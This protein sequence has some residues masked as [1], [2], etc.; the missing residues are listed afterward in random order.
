MQANNNNPEFLYSEPGGS[1]AARDL[2]IGK[3]GA[4]TGSASGGGSLFTD[5]GQDF[6]AAPF[7]TKPGDILRITA[8]SNQGDYVITA[9]NSGTEL[10]VGGEFVAEAGISYDIFDP[11]MPN[12]GAALSAGTPSDPTSPPPYVPG[13]VYI[14]RTQYNGLASATITFARNGVYDS[15]WDP[16]LTAGDFAKTYIHNLGALP[17]SVELWVRVDSTSPAYRPLVRRQVLTNFDTGDGTVDPTD[18]KTAELLVPSMFYSVTET[19]ITVD[20]FNATTDPA[21]PAALFTDSAGVDQVAGDLRV[22][23]RR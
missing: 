22:I 9:V 2:R 23:V 20:L 11:A 13:R 17:A 19:S 12:I 10:Q 7:A 16:G 21:N 4:G 8:G 18:P 6:N 15:G 3:S 5:G 1:P 14:G